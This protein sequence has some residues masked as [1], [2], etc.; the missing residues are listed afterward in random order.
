MTWRI[1]GPERNMPP[2]AFQERLTAAG[3]VNRYDSP[4]FI[5]WWSQ[6]A[7]E[8]GS[9]IAGGAWSV[10]ESAF[11]GYRRL[12]R[13]SGEPCWCLGQFHEAIEYGCPE[14][15]YVQNYDD[16][17]GLQ[18]LGAYPYSGRYELMYQL[19]W[20]E[21]VGPRM[22]FH[23]M[24]LTSWVFDMV[25]PIIM[26]AK[27]VSAEKRIAAFKESQKK[28]EDEKTA[29]I[30]R[31]LRANALPFTDTVSYT[32]QGIRST[33]IDAKVR[34]MHQYWNEMSNAARSLRPGLQTR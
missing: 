22:E 19:R 21:K 32:R 7:H 13:G 34:V 11:T 14:S 17:T 25:V 26:K 31:Q 2:E 27:E 12:L 16:S 9:F 6:Y 29:G 10:D 20:Y 23:T 8:E 4:N 5:V 30:E 1:V 18:M 3:G 24:P 15:Y 33:V 28:A